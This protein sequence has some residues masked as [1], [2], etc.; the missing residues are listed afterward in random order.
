MT[1]R[2]FLHVLPSFC[3]AGSQVRT[4]ALMRGLADSVRHTVIAIDGRTEAAA[5]VTGCDLT[6]QSYEPGA[7]PVAGIRFFRQLLQE[8]RP[9]LL[10]TYNWGAMDAA[11]AARS[12]GFRKQVHHED[13][14]NADEAHRLKLRRNWARRLLLNNID[15]VVPSRNLLSIARDKWHLRQVNFVPNGI[16]AESFVSDVSLAAAFR[17][18]HRIAAETVVVGTVGH[19]RRVKNFARLIR[20]LSRLKTLPVQLVIVGDGEERSALQEVAES[21]GVNV[22]FAGHLADPRAAYSA[23]DM[24]VLSSDS[25]Q[26]PISLLEA[27]AAGLPVCATDVGDIRA[28][29]PPATHQYLVPSNAD[30]DAGLATV[31]GELAASE[32]QRR[33]AGQLNLSHVK[34]NY[35]DLAMLKSYRELYARAAGLASL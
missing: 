14:F 13:G 16:S 11:I 27:M 17:E 35:S 20:A 33:A 4:T 18:E 19:L 26:Q 30:A 6:L 3:A 29:L 25:E 23:F 31:I 2:H 1:V 12:L 21:E 8:T 28:T 22:I 10:L 5:L 24:F 15:V 9:D 32:K 7:G 34:K